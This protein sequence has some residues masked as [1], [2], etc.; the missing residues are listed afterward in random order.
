MTLAILFAGK[1]E[2]HGLCEL[3][4]AATLL[5]PRIDHPILH[6]M[7]RPFE[8]FVCGTQDSVHLQ[9]YLARREQDFR[10]LRRRSLTKIGSDYASLPHFGRPGRKRYIFFGQKHAVF[11]ASQRRNRGKSDE[12]PLEVVVAC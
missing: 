4:F 9:K 1:A 3:A 12:E 7:A 2:I 8:R 6:P 11:R 10:S 5:R